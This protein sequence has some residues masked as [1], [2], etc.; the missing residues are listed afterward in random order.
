MSDTFTLRIDLG[1]AAMQTREDVAEAL[2]NIAEN[3]AFSTHESGTI[4]DANGNS[5]GSWELS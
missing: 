5:V 1:N 2:G 3:I 4:R